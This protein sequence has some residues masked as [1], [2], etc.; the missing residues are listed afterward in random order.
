MKVLL[1]KICS[2][3]LD[4]TQGLLLDFSSRQ[5]SIQTSCLRWF[6][7]STTETTMSDAVCLIPRDCNPPHE[8]LHSN[9]LFRLVFWLILISQVTRCTDDGA[10]CP[11]DSQTLR[12]RTYSCNK[13]ACHN[14]CNGPADCRKECNIRV[15]KPKEGISTRGH[16]F[17]S[18]LHQISI[19]GRKSTTLVCRDSGEENGLWYKPM[20]ENTCDEQR[21][22]PHIGQLEEVSWALTG[23]RQGNTQRGAF[24]GVRSPFAV[25]QHIGEKAVICDIWERC[26]RLR[27]VC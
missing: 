3:D 27:Q 2:F 6:H 26:Y 12:I 23:Y 13:Q 24:H 4:I 5:P 16:V 22:A 1:K 18:I 15:P 14:E 19:H 9:V 21:N 11:A 20:E 7:L 25:S 17:V 10:I 8:R